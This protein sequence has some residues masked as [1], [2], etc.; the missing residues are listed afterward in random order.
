MK[1]NYFLVAAASMFLLSACSNDEDITKGLEADAT[2]QELVL[3]VASSGDGLVTRASRPLYSSEADQS[4]DKVTIVITSTTDNTVKKVM[5]LDT[6]M[7]TSQS[8]ETGGHGRQQTIS[9][10]GDEKLDA[11]TY[12]VFAVGYN[13]ATSKFTFS[14]A[15]PTDATGSFTASAVTTTDKAEEIFAG[16]IASIKVNDKKAFDITLGSKGNVLTLHRQVAGAMGYF[17]NIPASVDGKDAATLR[18]VATGK[19]LKAKFEKFNSSFTEKDKNVQFIVNGESPAETKNAKFHNGADG[20]AYEVYS[21][22]L[23]DW[24]TASE[25]TGKLDNDGNGI[26]NNTDTWKNGIGGT[27]HGVQGS[28]FA[29]E[30]VIPFALTTGDATMELQLLDATGAII[31]YWGVS[32][33]DTDVAKNK[34]AP[35]VND[36]SASIFNVVRNHM[37]NIGVK[38]ENGTTDPEQPKPGTDD[39]E[40]LSKGQDIILK[41]NDNWEALHQLVI[42]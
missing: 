36:E 22:A 6:W 26:L 23:A 15:L 37:Y 5:S 35:E 9:F 41:V 30:F 1:K 38:M 39:P 32:I 12:K 31:K 3:Q 7:T 27:Y 25:T 4:I 28:V 13:T 24:F 18:L 42:D 21:I 40:D 11:G 8:Y 20:S 19:N 14:P 2:A 29:G 17:K 10:K 33:P 16:E 34:T